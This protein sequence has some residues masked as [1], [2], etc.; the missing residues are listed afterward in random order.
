MGENTAVLGSPRVG[1]IKWE[2]SSRCES[3]QPE[4]RQQVRGFGSNI[5]AVPMAVEGDGQDGGV[6]SGCSKSFGVGTEPGCNGA[7]W[8]QL[9]GDEGY[10]VVLMVPTAVTEV[11]RGSRLR[12]LQSAKVRAASA[13]DGL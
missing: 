13:D 2:R 1:G 11:S 4:N 10:C 8:A 5:P 9:L 12:L 6:M 3:E 7:D